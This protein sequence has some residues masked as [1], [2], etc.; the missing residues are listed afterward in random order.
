[1]PGADSAAATTARSA[2]RADAISRDEGPGTRGHRSRRLF[3]FL[4]ASA[5][6][7]LG[8]SFHELYLVH[9]AI[10]FYWGYQLL[11]LAKGRYPRSMGTR[12]HLPLVLVLLWY[13][14]SIVWVERLDHAGK[15]VGYL[16]CGLAIVFATAHQVQNKADLKSALTVLSRCFAV[17]LVICVLEMLTPFRYPISPYS[18]YASL[19]GRR[20]TLADIESPFA[21]AT[22][23]T[24]PTGFEW[25]PN[26]LAA[27][28][29]IIAP[30]IPVVAKGT[31][32]WLLRL[33]VI[34]LVIA[35]GSRASFLGLLVMAFL[36][37]A[38]RSWRHFVATFAIVA[39]AVLALPPLV[40][41]LSEIPGRVG[42]IAGTFEEV[43]HFAT[44]SDGGTGSVG[45]RQQLLR[46]GAEDL[47][48]TNGWGVGAGGSL[49]VQEK[50]GT[51]NGITSMHNF[52]FELLVEAG[53]YVGGLFILWYVALAMRLAV[54]EQR[55]G[56]IWLSEVARA[57]WI[58]MGSFSVAAVSASSTIYLF[59]MWL[60]LGI[61]IGVL[62][63]AKSVAREPDGQMRV[64]V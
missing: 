30:F 24:T 31:W 44:Q 12:Y 19:F 60:L 10:A 64:S 5:A 51:V 9:V 16:V 8:V 28:L 63:V 26:N 18:Q 34:A 55:F 29:V 7:S 47:D 58:A 32:K 21:L 11:Q 23:S 3:G 37:L 4:I 25:N 6:L 53:L 46:N 45:I 35:T 33:T 56:D 43:V 20:F 15:Y 14:W 22:L 57:C 52:W 61:A 2:L 49:T 40:R 39:A 1:M 36:S 54:L 38:L 59:P 41:A 13:F 48:R 62:N 50:R 17:E 42:E 27:T